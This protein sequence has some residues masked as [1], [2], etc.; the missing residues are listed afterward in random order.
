MFPSQC[1]S[2]F[3]CSLSVSLDCELLSLLKLFKVFVTQHQNVQTTIAIKIIEKCF[4]VVSINIEMQ[5]FGDKAVF[6]MYVA[7]IYLENTCK[8]VAG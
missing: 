3:H 4:V 6:V 1:C 7:T 5:H 8:N 2:F